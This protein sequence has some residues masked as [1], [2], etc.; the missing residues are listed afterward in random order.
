MQFIKN[1]LKNEELHLNDESN[2][3]V[4]HE[5]EAPNSQL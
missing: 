1:T 2:Y 3:M 5:R 4:I